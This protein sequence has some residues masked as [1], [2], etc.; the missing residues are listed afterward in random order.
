MSIPIHERTKQVNSAGAAIRDALVEYGLT[1]AE[2]IYV[3]SQT[4]HS[5]AN[6]QLSAE[7]G[8]RKVGE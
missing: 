3:L 1:D 4:I 5:Y 8:V 2:S 6:D 7:R